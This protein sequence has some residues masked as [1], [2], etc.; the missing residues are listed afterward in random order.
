MNYNL[1]I[2]FSFLVVFISCKTDKNSSSKEK[3]LINE[4]KKIEQLANENTQKVII[5]SQ[6]TYEELKKYIGKIYREHISFEDPNLRISGGALISG[7]YNEKEYSLSTIRGKNDIIHYVFFEEV[8]SE[9]NNPSFRII[10]ILKIDKETQDLLSNDDVELYIVMSSLDQ[11][12]DE[13]IIAIATY[14]DNEVLTKIHK[15]WRAD[16]KT[17]KIIEINTE[18]II[19][20]NVL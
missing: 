1:F 17:E 2:A 13:E 3:N 20:E 12:S 4:E 16:R 15:A 11:T 18:G 7:L 14:E 19:V 10:D 9:N 6:N 5:S 8:T